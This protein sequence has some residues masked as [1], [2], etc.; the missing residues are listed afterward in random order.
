MS[1]TFLE[2]TVSSD[3]VHENEQ[4]DHQNSGARTGEQDVRIPGRRGQRIQAGT[5]V[6]VPAAVNACAEKH[7]NHAPQKDF[8]HA[9]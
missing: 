2:I 1:R 8:Q 6:K 7:A 5:C 4:D 9:V 3:T